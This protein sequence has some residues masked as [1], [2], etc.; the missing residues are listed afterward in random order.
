VSIKATELF[1]AT[2]GELTKKVD[3]SI[4]HFDTECG[5]PKE[6]KRG[7]PWKSTRERCGGTDFDAPTNL[8]NNPKNRGRWD[9]VLIMTDGVC[10]KPG[11]SRLRRGWVIEPGSKLNFT[12]DELVIEPSTDSTIHDAWL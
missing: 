11:S 3:I 10:N 1:F 4:V 6:W 8:A 12:T 5:E 7:Q 2:L 9:G